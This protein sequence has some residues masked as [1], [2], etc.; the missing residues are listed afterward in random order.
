VSVA[1][2]RTKGELEQR[3]NAPLVHGPRSERRVRRTAGYVKQS[4][5]MP[6]GLRQSDLSR[7]GRYWLDQW[8]I[9]QAQVKLYDDELERIG[10]L[11]DGGIPPSFMR[12]YY[13][14]RGLAS[15]TRMKLEPHLLEAVEHKLGRS[16]DPVE[17][18]N[19]FLEENYG[20]RDGAD[21]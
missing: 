1:A 12:T 14:A 2:K 7:T 19:R 18:L 21:G 9:P 13:A 5:L 15:R 4:L 11:A 8:A 17:R 16:A 3:R 10:L 20:S 6:L